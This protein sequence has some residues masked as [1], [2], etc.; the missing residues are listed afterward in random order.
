M[1]FVRAQGIQF[2]LQRL[3]MAS[4]PDSPSPRP[5]VVMIH[6]LF[7]GSLASWYFTAAPALAAS[8]RVLLYDLRGHGRTQRVADGYNLDTMA[9]DLVE[10]ICDEPR[11]ILVG[12]SYGGLI[13]LRV[14]M[15]H[16]ERVAGLALVDVPLPPSEMGE[17]SEIGSL[18]ARSP[19]EMLAAL[20][21][22]V[23]VLVERG[24]RQA[25]RLVQGLAFL[26]HETTLLSDLANEPDIADHEL[27]GIECDV[28]CFYGNASSCLSAGQRLVGA[29]PGA[30]FTVLPGGHYLHLDAPGELT[31]HLVEFVHV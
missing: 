29:V 3:G 19:E 25:R 2:H 6:G 9:R 21:D 30:S 20:P 10:L 27:A 23:R 8:H 31:R 14:A 28:A 13:A 12:H 26:A 4:E 22:A 16:P 11:V 15:K 7:T 5:T 1:P 18:L 17:D 24:S